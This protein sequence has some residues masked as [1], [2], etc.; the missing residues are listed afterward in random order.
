MDLKHY[1][2]RLP[3]KVSPEHLEGVNSTFHFDVSGE[4][5]G[6]YS[7]IAKD[8]ELHIEDGLVGEADCKVSG[9]SKNVMAIL[10]KKMHPL[11]AIMF[12]KVKIQNQAE[13]MRWAKLLGMIK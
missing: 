1:I 3:D 6:Q 9:K 4:G 2:H 8:G 7:I 10:Q 11:K 13:L 12:G 5:G